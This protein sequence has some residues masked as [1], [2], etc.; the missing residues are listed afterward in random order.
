VTQAT[1]CKPPQNKS[2]HLRRQR[3]LE[4][5][6]RE[7]R[8]RP[9]VDA[10]RGERHAAARLGDEAVEGE[11]EGEG[12]PKLLLAL[13]AVEGLAA[14]RVPRA[15]DGAAGGVGVRRVLGLFCVW[16]AGCVGC[17]MDAAALSCRAVPQ[18]ITTQHSTTQHKQHNKLTCESSYSSLSSSAVTRWQCLT[19]SYVLRPALPS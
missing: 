19:M 16:E 4:L 17:V 6:R 11:G 3:V 10:G 9:V 13:P 2:T 12:R 7:L 1:T 18:Y 8:H 5:L 15:R 14:L